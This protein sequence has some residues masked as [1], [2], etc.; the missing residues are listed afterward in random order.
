MDK[1]RLI[2]ELQTR[3]PAASAP[4]AVT[5]RRLGTSEKEIL[6]TVKTALADGTIREFGPVFDPRRLGYVST[7]VAAEVEESSIETCAEALNP[8]PEITHN[9]LRDHTINLWFTVIAAGRERLQTVIGKAAALR[10]VARVMSLPVKKVFKIRAVWDSDESGSDVQSESCEPPVFDETARRLV[11]ALQDGFPIVQYPFSVIAEKAEIPEQVVLN[12]VGNWIENGVI[13]RFGARLNH[14]SIGYTVN[15]LAV[16]HGEDAESLGKTFARL[17]AVSHCYLREPQ[18]DWP[19]T[20]YT[21][22]HAHSDHEG[23]KLLTSMR[24]AAPGAT[25]ATLRTLREL[26]KT[27]MKYFRENQP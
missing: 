23:D 8:V 2:R 13:R 7:L 15:I 4:F 20:L 25:V 5:A 19:Y 1:D 16:W 10:G 18:P 24:T 26:K 21:M 27:N 11:R 14:R 9:Y 3:F 17:P 12:M 6:D 22:I